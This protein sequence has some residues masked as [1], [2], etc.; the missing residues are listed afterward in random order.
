MS[1]S[2]QID[3]VHRLNHRLGVVLPRIAG[4]HVLDAAGAA[5]RVGLNAWYD[6]RM[7]LLARNPLSPAA[8]IELA[9]THATLLKVLRM[10]RRKCL[11]LDLDHTLWGG[12]VGEKGVSGIALGAEY[13]GNAFVQFQ[14]F[15]LGL[16]QRGVLLALLSKNNPGDVD[17]VFD[18]HPSMILRREHFAA[19]RINW[20]PKAEN[21]AEI[22][23]ELSIGTDAFVFFDDDAAECEWMR[24]ARPDV[25]T[26]QAPADLTAFSEAIVR[27]AAFERLSLSD[28]DRRRG[29]MYAAGTA[30][31]EAAAAATSVDDFLKTLDMRAVVEPVG[32]HQLPR[33]VDLLAKTNQFNVTTRR[34]SAAAVAAMTGS[35]DHAAFTLQ[36]RDRFGDNGLVGVAIVRRQAQ[37]AVIDSLL[38][39][40][41]VIGRQAE[42][43]LLS[44]LAAWA[45]DQ[46]VETLVGEYIPTARNAPAADCYERHGFVPLPASGPA[47][48]WG[49]PVQA[50]GI[51]WPSCIAIE[52]GAPA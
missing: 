14:Q 7:W 16:H 48:R 2:S 43:A 8:M 15:L 38:L 49:L 52:T 41:R 46:G 36:L 20:R 9:R 6:D 5:A 32:G 12:I 30:R 23:N 13:P 45:R 4:V 28:E 34:H 47:A 31:R 17:E 18:R 3:A 21:L 42:T 19:M 51:T 22:A 10:P 35:S 37:D 40:C 1:E 25:L 27:T 29:E 50:R 24:N 33:V 26:I 39:S 44:V 11:A